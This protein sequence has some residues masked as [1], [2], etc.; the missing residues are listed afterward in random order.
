VGAQRHFKTRC[1]FYLLLFFFDICYVNIWSS[2]NRKYKQ[3]RNVSTCVLQTG[4]S[5]FLNN[6]VIHIDSAATQNIKKN[7]KKWKKI[8]YF[9]CT[10]SAERETWG[11]SI[12]KSDHNVTLSTDLY[13][14]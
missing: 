2:N 14:S 3:H 9:A 7:S 8:Y 4:Y 5:V 11:R 13:R 10:F 6:I 12:P 1:D